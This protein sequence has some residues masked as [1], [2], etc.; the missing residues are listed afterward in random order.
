M[1]FK[2]TVLYIALIFLILFLGFIGYMMFKS[3][4]SMKYPPEV[5]E[6]P[7]YFRVVGLEKCDNTMNLGSCSGVTDFSGSEW[8]GKTGLKKKYEWAKRC[9]VVWDG[10]TNNSRFHT[11]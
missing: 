8:Q 4:S 3:K 7:D 2:K 9:G 11:L 1:T 6:C 10:I 5:A